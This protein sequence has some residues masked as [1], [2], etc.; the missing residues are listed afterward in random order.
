MK[1]EFTNNPQTQ[2]IDFLSEK[3]NLGFKSYGSAHAFG[4]FIRDNGKMIAG[5]NGSVVYNFIYIDQLWVHQDYRSRG[6]GKQL[7]EA[8]H[9]YGH[10]VGCQMVTVQTMSFQNAESFYEKLGYVCDFKRDMGDYHC[11]FLKK[12][13]SF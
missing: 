13:L 6:I 3:I 2:D 10:K 11:I 12:T 8:V 9:N 1:I 4:F 7:M 5:C